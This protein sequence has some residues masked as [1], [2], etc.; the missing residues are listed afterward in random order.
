MTLI[1]TPP[2]I[3]VFQMGCIIF[4]PES[5]SVVNLT[6]GGGTSEWRNYGLSQWPKSSANF[7][8]IPLLLRLPLCPHGAKTLK[9]KPTKKVRCPQPTC[10]NCHKSEQALTGIKEVTLSLHPAAQTGRLPY[11]GAASHIPHSPFVTFNPGSF[12]MTLC[13]KRT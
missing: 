11:R 13:P 12:W 9:Q 8:K 5:Y 6:L 1:G 7:L 10:I 3:C 4:Y 2:F